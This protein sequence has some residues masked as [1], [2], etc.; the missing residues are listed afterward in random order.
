MDEL[1]EKGRRTFDDDERKKAYD[2]FQEVLR[3]D[4][5][6]TFLYVPDSTLILHAR[7]RNVE[8][9]PAGIFWNFPFWYVPKAEQKYVITP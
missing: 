5:P 1:L 4:Q 9:T 3:E 8:E 7:F 6:Y 2:R